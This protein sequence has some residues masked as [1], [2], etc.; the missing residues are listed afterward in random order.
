M[1][2]TLKRELFDGQRLSMK[3][4]KPHGDER[5]RSRSRSPPRRERRR[6][7]DRRDRSRD[8]DR[9]SRRRRDDDDSRRYR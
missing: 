9:D 5:D 6:S 7:R 8:Y 1:T 3:I 2:R 4:L